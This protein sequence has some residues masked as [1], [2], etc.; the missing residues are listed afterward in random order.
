MDC[1][2]MI[3]NIIAIITVD[4]RHNTSFVIISK[5]ARPR[6]AYYVHRNEAKRKKNNILRTILC[7]VSD[8]YRGVEGALLSRV[9]CLD[10]TRTFNT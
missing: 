6:T 9:I 7:R 10:T 5:L 3:F 4:R 1:I 8:G 2:N